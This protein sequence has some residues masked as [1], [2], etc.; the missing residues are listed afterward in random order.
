MPPSFSLTSCLAAALR[1]LATYWSSILARGSS[2]S[3][4]TQSPTS[5]ETNNSSLEEAGPKAG[6]Q[7]QQQQ[8]QQQQQQ[9]ALAAAQAQAATAEVRGCL[10]RSGLLLCPRHVQRLPALPSHGALSEDP[11][12]RGG[13]G[14]AGGGDGARPACQPPSPAGALDKLALALLAAP[15]RRHSSSL[16]AGGGAEEGGSPAY[17]EGAHDGTCGSSS[18]SGAQLE[19]SK[20]VGAAL[21]G[22]WMES[23]CAGSSM[24]LSL[25]A[26][27]PS[28]AAA[29]GRVMEVLEG[30][31]RQVGGVG[32]HG[33]M[34]EHTHELKSGVRGCDGERAC[35]LAQ[36]WARTREASS[37]GACT[38]T[39]VYMCGWTMAVGVLCARVWA[40]AGQVFSAANRLCTSE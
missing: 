14:K 31:C 1:F 11:A 37:S 36:V 12:A 34:R 35:A 29:E 15:V 40:W 2:S 16:H 20:A 19:R 7:S 22:A 18:N 26:A 32:E 8:Q 10:E 39:R 13:S 27:Q 28:L 23:A 30:W 38:W 21:T 3:V 5:N 9:L 33:R 4:P 17:E 24:V 6:H 25:R